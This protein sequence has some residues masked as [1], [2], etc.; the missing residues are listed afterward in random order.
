[1]FTLFCILDRICGEWNVISLYF[2]CC[3]INGSV[4]LVSC[5]SDSVC[6][7]YE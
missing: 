6:E 4:C 1:M 7:F 3:L 2:L 5:V